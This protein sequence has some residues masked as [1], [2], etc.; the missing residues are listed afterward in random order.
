M[1]RIVCFSI[2]HRCILLP[3][4]TLLEGYSVTSNKQ[5]RA[6]NIS[7]LPQYDKYPVWLLLEI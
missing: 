1:K 7:Y 6:P 5:I 2:F 4:M 3:K